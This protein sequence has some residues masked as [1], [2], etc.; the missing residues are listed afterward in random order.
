MAS[1]GHHN[2][3]TSAAVPRIRVDSRGWAKRLA[4]MGAFRCACR[5]LASAVPGSSTNQAGNGGQSQQRQ[6]QRPPGSRT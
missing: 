6:A 3:L 2:T 1:L 4:Y 5:W